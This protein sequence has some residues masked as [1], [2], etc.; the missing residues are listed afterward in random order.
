MVDSHDQASHDEVQLMVD[1]VNLWFDTE[2][3]QAG[4]KKKDTRI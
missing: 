1:E 4:L 2:A 3:G